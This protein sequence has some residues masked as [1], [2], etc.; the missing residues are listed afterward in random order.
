M[1]L[2][3]EIEAK[4]K[5]LK[6]LTITGQITCGTMDMG[7]E[8]VV[9]SSTGAEGRL[10][11]MGQWP[12][13]KFAVNEALRVAVQGFTGDLAH[14]VGLIKDLNFFGYCHTTHNPVWP[15]APHEE[16][17]DDCLDDTSE[18]IIEQLK[19]LDLSIDHFFVYQDWDEIAL[20]TSD[21]SEIE[22]QFIRHHG[23]TRKWEDMD[24]DEIEYWY[25]IAE[26]CGWTLPVNDFTEDD[27]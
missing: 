7:L 17:E 8:S 10:G 16:E 5:R 3:K 4:L 6:S 23:P 18:S 27:E 19:T 25:D 12:C 14:D 21:F 24:E 26:E 2:S 11:D 9:I 15:A 20:L 13:S 1:A 22:Q